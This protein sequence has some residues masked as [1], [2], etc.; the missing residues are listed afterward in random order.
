[1]FLVLCA[2]IKMREKP[3]REICPETKCLL[4]VP[5]PLN[6]FCLRK[7]RQSCCLVDFIFLSVL[8]AVYMASA[9]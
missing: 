2:A 8:T 4:L 6:N 1:M 9:Y 5:N 7:R 3:E